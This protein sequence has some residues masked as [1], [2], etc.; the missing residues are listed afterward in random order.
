MLGVGIDWSEDFHVAA[1]AGPDDVT[2]TLRRVDHNPFALEAFIAQLHALEP[3]PTLVRVVLETSHGV[4]VRRLI[5]AGF[6]VMPVNPDLVA[7]RRNSARKK[8]DSEDARIACRMALDIRE[9]LR[10]LVPH[11]PDAAELQ[12]LARDDA[13]LGRDERRLTNRLRADLIAVYPAAVAIAAGEYGRLTFLRMLE[14]W[15][16]QDQLVPV[17]DDELLEFAKA[18]GNRWRKRWAQRVR[19]ALDTEQFVVPEHLMRAKAGTIRFN[20]GRLL[21]LHTERQR[22]ARRIEEIFG[23]DE[24]RAPFPGSEIYLSFPGLGLLL[25]ARVAGEIGQNIEVFAVPAALKAYAGKAPVTRKSGKSEHIIEH[26]QA[27][28]HALGD[29]AQTWAFCSL[30]CSS[31]ARDYYAAQRGR[32]KSHH[33]ALRALANRWLGILWHCLTTAQHY[34]E[35]IHVANRERMQPRAA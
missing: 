3:E 6:T 26:R 11:S 22:L 21:A 5:E 13:R 32:G 19:V 2:F 27:H 12:A 35:N 18:C 24:D 23:G 4:L 29:A 17:S 30:S 34:D 28:N 10:P 25:A 16:S 8:D 31:W 14:R 9:G 7:R 20:A 1:L 33:G 15:P